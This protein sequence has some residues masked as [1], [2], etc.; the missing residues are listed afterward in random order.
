MKFNIL[1]VDPPWLMSDPLTMSKTKRGAASNYKGVLKLDEIKNIDIPSISAD[2]S[3]LAL[4]VPSAML[5]E[6]L[7]VMK[8]W[9]FNYKQNFIWVKTK[10]D[11]F[12]KL[13]KFAQKDIH[14]HFKKI[15]NEQK[16]Y[17]INLTN[18]Y[19]HIKDDILPK[20]DYDF[21]SGLQ[22]LMGR[23]FRQTHEICLIGIKGKV[24]KFRENKSQISV[25]M[26]P[27]LKHSAKPEGLQDRLD[28]M[29]PNNNLKRVELFARRQRDNYLCLGNEAPMSNEEDI[30][31]SV[32]KLSKL[33]IKDYKK[34]LTM[35]DKQNYQ[36]MEEFWVNHGI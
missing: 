15:L 30:I 19:N 11:P 8:A 10:I 23:L 25:H 21:N 31:S 34:L 33:K 7:M 20:F 28:L 35:A 32:E 22:F 18:F 27:P 3:L 24:S 36:D 14:K 4:W 16:N 17:N 29:M 2:D 9:D 5:P 26:H 13:I 12:G 1:V 6:G